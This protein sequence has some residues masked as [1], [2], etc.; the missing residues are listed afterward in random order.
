[1]GRKIT[2]SQKLWQVK[3]QN[4]IGTINNLFEYQSIL[5]K[6]NPHSGDLG[7]LAVKHISKLQ[8]VVPPCLRLGYA[9]TS[10]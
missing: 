10:T 4:G 8:K 1:M 5:V 2:V 9:C 7:T 3:V 6:I